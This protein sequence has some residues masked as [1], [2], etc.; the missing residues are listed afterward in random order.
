MLVSL[1]IV[2]CSSMLVMLNVVLYKNNNPSGANFRD[3]LIQELESMICCLTA[4]EIRLWMYFDKESLPLLL[5]S[6]FRFYWTFLWLLTSSSRNVE[7]NCYCQF[8]VDHTLPGP[9][10]AP[11]VW[12]T[13]ETVLD[14]CCHL[15]I[16]WIRFLDFHI[17]PGLGLESSENH[18][19]KVIQ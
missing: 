8:N 6:V 18:N 7:L 16:L 4:G 5:T 13:C 15:R 14:L 12:K 17:I 2:Y 11:R 9:S 19:R 3:T 10:V 1:F